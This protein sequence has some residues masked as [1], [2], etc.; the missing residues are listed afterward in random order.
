[1][2]IVKVNSVLSRGIAQVQQAELDGLYEM[3]VGTGGSEAPDHTPSGDPEKGGSG[4]VANMESATEQFMSYLGQLA[5][6]CSAE[7]GHSE[8]KSLDYV[9]A[10]ADE[11]SAAGE[12]PP[13]PDPDSSSAEELAAWPLAAKQ[14]GFAKRLSE[15]V[16]MKNGEDPNVG[17]S[18]H[19]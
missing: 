2:D 11:M 5:A 9:M 12:I 6:N 16:K 19:A 14:A 7:G 15:Y 8:D 17:T 13:I 4:G 10:L 1:M 3:Y 18:S